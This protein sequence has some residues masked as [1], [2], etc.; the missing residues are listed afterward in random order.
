MAKWSNLYEL[1]DNLIE[2]HKALQTLA[3]QKK[4]VLIKGDVDQL[5]AITTQEKKLIKAVSAAEDTRQSL[6]AQMFAEQGIHRDNG[7]LAELI[8][9]TTSPEEKARL[10]K[11]RDELTRIISELRKANELNQQLLE[12]S[13][14]FVNMTLDL[15]TDSPEDDF[16]YG[17]TARSDG[18][19]NHARTF[20]NKK[21]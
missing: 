6:V 7:T 13:L 9:L 5:L 20:F 10:M 18:Y 14:S 11:A 21:A 12:Q 19:R 2:L 3:V 4:E 16:F 15:V 17:R 8:K 1:L